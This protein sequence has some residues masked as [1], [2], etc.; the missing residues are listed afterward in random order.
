MALRH[1]FIVILVVA[2]WAFNVVAIKL[3]VTE[4]PPLFMTFLRFIVVSAVVVPFARVTREQ[5]KTLMVL[6]FTFGFMHFSL[7]FVGTRYTDAGTAAIVVQLGTPF[8]MIMAAVVLKEKLS[9]IQVMGI[10]I[11][12]SGVLYKC[13]TPNKTVGAN[14][15]PHDRGRPIYIQ[16]AF[17]ITYI[18]RT[19]LLILHVLWFGVAM[20]RYTKCQYEHN[21]LRLTHT[22]LQ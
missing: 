3:G 9:F 22:S 21:K 14:F 19:K 13:F 4:L 1:F 16:C 18:M 7:L 10:A 8:A 12:L 5:L 17:N 6:A 11:S 20:A 15:S 2:I